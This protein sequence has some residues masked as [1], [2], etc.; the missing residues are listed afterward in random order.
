M[1]RWK[2]KGYVIILE[3]EERTEEAMKENRIKE[4]KEGGQDGWNWERR[5]KGRT[6][7]GNEGNAMRGNDRMAEEKGKG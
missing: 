1:I 3:R 4:I 2:C 6:R 5:G 7:E